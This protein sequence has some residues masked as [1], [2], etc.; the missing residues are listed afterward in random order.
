MKERI[1]ILKARDQVALEEFIR[2][3]F[4]EAKTG[5]IEIQYT[6]I[7]TRIIIHTVTPGLIVG[8]GG[9]RIRQIVEELKTK[10][11]IKNPQIDVQRIENQF[12]DPHVVSQNIAQQLEHG[13]N[14][15]RLGEFYVQKIMNSG[16]TGCEL[17]FAGKVSGQRARTERF[18]AGYLKKCGD[19]A[20]KDVLKGFAIANP[21]L[22]NIGVKVKIMLKHKEV[23]KSALREMAKKTVP[24][25]T[26]DQKE[27]KEPK[28]E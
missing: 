20:Q 27:T 28:E 18:S 5:M 3:R 21:K 11:N 26:K 6:P 4:D 17:V 13:T 22:G 25:E 15:K 2:S 10:F 8:S 23:T 7:V 16:A 24:K 9:E 1:F 12:L 19:P 14:F